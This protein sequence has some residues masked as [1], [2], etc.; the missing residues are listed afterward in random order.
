MRGAGAP[1][2]DGAPRVS[3]R[4]GYCHNAHINM[5]KK[6][7]GS[8]VRLVWAGLAVLLVGVVTGC[9]SSGGGSS[10]QGSPESD[11]SRSN[12]ALGCE[13]FP[14]DNAWH[15]DVSGLP[16]HPRSDD[17]ISSMGG[18]DQQLHAD[19]GPSYGEQPIPYGI[20]FDVVAGDSPKVEV[21]FSG[22]APQESDPGPYPFGAETQ[23]EGGPD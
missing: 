1:G 17:W 16:V 12:S 20:P 4:H 14:E 19:F 5:R 3:Y 2:T 9:G 6:G 13:V 7:Y 22:G 8:V 23:I 11:S 18:P 15:A 10:Q 21:D